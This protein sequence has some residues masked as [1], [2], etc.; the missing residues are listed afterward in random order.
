MNVYRRKHSTAKA[1]MPVT[2]WKRNGD[3]PYEEILG[4]KV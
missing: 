3:K 2:E 4:S 1:D